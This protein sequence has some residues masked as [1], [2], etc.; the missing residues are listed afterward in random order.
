M[1]INVEL[2]GFD[3]ANQELDRIITRFVADA[4]STLTNNLRSR[5]PIDTGRARRGWTNR[6]SGRTAS[7]E[8]RVPYIDYLEQGHSRQA[9]TGFVRQ[10]ISATVAEMNRKGKL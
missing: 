9:P 2:Q 3:Q 10:A 4:S 1:R 5:T 8:N 6:A 7:V